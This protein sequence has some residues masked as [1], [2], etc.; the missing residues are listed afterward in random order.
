M[1]GPIAHDALLS[2]ALPRSSAL[3]PSKSRRFTSLPS[4]APMILPREFTPSTISGS[5]LFHVDL[6]ILRPR[7]LLDEH[8][9][10]SRR[11]VGAGA[12]RGKIVAED[13][14][15][16]GSNRFRLVRVA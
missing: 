5:G 1:K 16:T 3:R 13:S 6:E 7:A 4:V 12:D 10:D 2:F 15:D 9:L 14:V 8:L 11:F